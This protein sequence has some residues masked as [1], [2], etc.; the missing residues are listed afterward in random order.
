MSRLKQ[1]LQRELIDPINGINTELVVVAAT[2][3]RMSF[4]KL[5]KYL[6]NMNYYVNYNLKDPITGIKNGKKFI[7]QPHRR[8]MMTCFQQHGDKKFLTH[9]H[10]LLRIPLMYNQDD[11]LKLMHEGFNKLDS[12]FSVLKETAND[13]I[14]NV[15]YNSR[16]F[17][18]NYTAEDG[19]F[20]IL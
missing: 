18:D 9:S 3:E 5:I 4:N 7:V 20:I 14:A 10:I 13:N 15:I 11:V 19:S 17:K 6:N 8:V 2:K 1:E 12:K 16:Q